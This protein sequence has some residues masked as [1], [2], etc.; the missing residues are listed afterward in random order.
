MSWTGI[1]PGQAWKK[2]SA[3]DGAKGPRVY[4]WARDSHP[5]AA[6]TPPAYWLL[7]RRALST[8]FCGPEA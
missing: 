5:P 2:T 7:V 8:R 1:L 4:H 3:G 6:E